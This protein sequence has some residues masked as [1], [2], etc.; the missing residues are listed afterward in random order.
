MRAALDLGTNSLRLLVAKV[1]SQGLE[2]LRKEV[3]VV[4]LGQ[5]VDAAG[6]LS[7]AAMERTLSALEELAALIPRGC[8]W[9]PLPPAQ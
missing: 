9:L 7:P 3:R 4:R 1:T 8:L 2:P 6:K 5:G